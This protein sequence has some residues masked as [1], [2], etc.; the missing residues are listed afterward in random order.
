MYK[1]LS[2]GQYFNAKTQK[3]FNYNPFL[4]GQTIQTMSGTQNFYT[5]DNFID[6]TDG[7]RGVVPAF[8]LGVERRKSTIYAN[9]LDFE[10]ISNGKRPIQNQWINFVH[11]FEPERAYLLE[12][13]KNKLYPSLIII[14]NSFVINK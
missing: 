8:C 6:L 12:V 13:V 9:F 5:Y 11:D 1:K 2:N 3:F 7:E 10:Y 4:E 14:K